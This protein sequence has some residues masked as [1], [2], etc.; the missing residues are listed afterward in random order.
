MLLLYLLVFVVF[1]YTSNLKYRPTFKVILL[2]YLASIVCAC[3]LW[4]LMPEQTQKYPLYFPGI[5]YHI[6]VLVLM[7]LPLRKFDRILAPE[8]ITISYRTLRPFLLVLVGLSFIS[9]I[10]SF[11][12]YSIIISSGMSF[13]EGRVTSIQG[14]SFMRIIKPSGSILAHISAIASEFSY[15]SLFF[16]FLIS[17]RYPGH[18]RMVAALFVASLTAIFFQLEWFGRENIVRYFLDGAIVFVMFR[19]LMAESMKK[20]LKRGIIVVGI[21]FGGLF[22]SITV[23]RFGGDSDY[24][25]GPVYGALSYFGQGIYYF[26]PVFN[27]YDGFDGETNGRTIFAIFFDKSERGSIF[28]KASSYSGTKDIPH[29]SFT[30]YVGSFVSDLGAIPAFFVFLVLIAFFLLVGK[31]KSNNIFTY[32]YILW[33]YKFFTQ[34][35]FYWVDIWATTDILFCIA[36]VFILNILYNTRQSKAKSL[37]LST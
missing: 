26:S 24:D 34:G 35:V 33:I 8:K 2:L 29:N 28:N 12:T 3:F 30:T 23:S 16:A 11:F 32:I 25:N 14:D 1:Y 27:A 17:V 9:I 21:I 7:M 13:L 18:R 22:T 20:R 15:L 37:G 31:M 5:I 4:Y 10:S 36:L 19:P 6:V